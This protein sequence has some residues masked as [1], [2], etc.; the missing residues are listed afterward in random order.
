MSDDPGSSAPTPDPGAG[1]ALCAR[2]GLHYDPRSQRGCV[3]CRRQAAATGV[4]GSGA[5]VRP[6]RR[7][8]RLALGCALSLAAA[9]L[10]LRVLPG[11]LREPAGNAALG[12]LELAQLD[13]SATPAPEPAAQARARES[14]PAPLQPL[15]VLFIGNS[16]TFVNEMPAMIAQLAAAAGQKRRFGYRRETPG[17]FGFSDHLANGAFRRQLRPGAWDFVVLQEQGQR[18]G[19]PSPVQRE[20]EFYAPARALYRE[21]QSAGVQPVFYQHFARRDG[22]R[23]NDASDSYEAMQARIIAGYESVARELGAAVVPVGAAW[24]Q[25]HRQQ[26]TLELWVADGMHPTVA[27][28]Y[29]TACVFYAYFYGQSPAGNQYQ[30]GLPPAVARTLQDEAEQIWIDGGKRRL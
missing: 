8:Q 28:S 22:D 29:L 27:G 10:W 9:L 17:G 20:N 2:H 25:V 24:A 4:E 3:L 13:A 16:L 23:M 11:L 18:A 30:A 6:V 7:W 26:P 21:V 15:R 1:L 5:A 12:Q 14:T 19:W